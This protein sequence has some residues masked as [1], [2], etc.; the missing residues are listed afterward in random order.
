M[1]ARAY[2]EADA[3][4][5]EAAL[6]ASRNGTFLFSR[7]YMG[8]HESRFP[9]ASLLIG[10]EGRPPA[11]LPACEAGDAVASHAGLSYGGL[12]V[13]PGWG[14]GEA[15]AALTEAAE[16]ARA[17]G[18]RRLTYRPVPAI[19]HRA[20]AEEDRAALARLGARLTRSDALAVLPPGGPPPASARRRDIARGRRAGITLGWSEEWEAYWALLTA[21]LGIHHGVAPV[22]SLAEIT[23]LAGR[24]PWNIR[25]FTAARAGRLLGGLVL[26][27]APPVLHVQYA[28]GND[29]ARATRALDA[30]FAAAIA[31]AHAEGLTFDFGVSSGPSGRG[32]GLQR[33][34]ESFGARAVMQ[35]TYEL[36]L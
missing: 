29:E 4:A 24:F 1:R 22:H 33:Y 30:A 32:A 31:G 10:R 28:A 18:A 17:R 15:E 5:W 35:D 9:D 27:R 25:L 26:Y 16:A 34:K 6:R 12:V 11:L 8:Y 2:A 21:H 20:P 36:E 19:Y 23:L 14:L 3:P 13:P 7:P